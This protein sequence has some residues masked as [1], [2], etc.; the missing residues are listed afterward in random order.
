MG[1][2]R[3]GSRLFVREPLGKR[4]EKLRLRPQQLC[5]L[6]RIDAVK[7]RR[8]SGTRVIINVGLKLR[9]R[10]GVNSM[11]TGESDRTIVSMENGFQCAGCGEWNETRVDESAGHRQTTLKIARCVAVRMF[12]ES[13]TIWN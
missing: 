9:R 3:A 11:P 5:S 1:Q 2:R 10:S 4:A 13:N 8:A 12:C 6:A 7:S